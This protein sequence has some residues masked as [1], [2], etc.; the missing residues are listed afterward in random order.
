M[1][2]YQNRNPSSTLNLLFDAVEFGFL[3]RQSACGPEPVGA[4]RSALCGAGHSK[5]SSDTRRVS[6][7]VAV[8]GA[9][10]NVEAELFVHAFGSDGLVIGSGSA[11]RINPMRM[12]RR[13]IGDQAAGPL[14]LDCNDNVVGPTIGRTAE[15]LHVQLGLVARAIDALGDAIQAALPASSVLEAEELWIRSVEACVDIPVVR[16]VSAVRRLQQSAISGA[17]R[18]TFD[19][20]RAQAADE[21]GIPVVRWWPT[22][23]GPVFKCYPKLDGIMRGEVVYPDRTA[24]RAGLSGRSVQSYL[25]GQQA[26]VLLLD[27]GAGLQP[28]L[29][30][31]VSHVEQVLENRHATLDLWD[32]LGGFVELA[33]GRLGAKGRPAGLAST[34][35]AREQLEALLTTGTCRA[36]GLPKAAALHAMFLRLVSAGVLARG[37]RGATYTLRPEWASAAEG[38]AALVLR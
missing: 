4:F 34:R 20:Y 29:D 25:D 13:H 15:L 3:A 26:I 38:V 32:H 11:I 22:E 8:P 30:R 19:V 27:A 21:K 9:G 10:F 24:V 1:M 31:L 2:P 6:L 28:L 23:G 5:A 14:S 35:A 16:A 12:L 7:S 36:T 17:T 37:G 18:S 33:F